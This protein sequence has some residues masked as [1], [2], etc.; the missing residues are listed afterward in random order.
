MALPHR[1]LMAPEGLEQ[2][3]EAFRMHQGRE[4][5][6]V[7]GDWVTETNPNFGAGIAARFA[8]ARGITD[9]EFEWACRQR[10]TITSR[11]LE[12]IGANTVIVLPTSP[13][14]APKRD[15]DQ[16]A[17]DDFRARALEILCPAGHAGLPQISIPA[18]T[19]DGGPVGLSLIAPRNGEETL[20]AI[21]AE[22]A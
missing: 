18:G 4:V 16:A 17:L 8:M 15:A 7:H 9:D 6:Q 3:R 11:M 12:L 5:W 19:V 1:S 13:G 21:A 20:L 2:W 10:S 22:L 14:P